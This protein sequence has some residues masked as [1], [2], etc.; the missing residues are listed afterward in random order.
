MKWVL[1]YWL[2]AGTYTG[3]AGA[4]TGQAYFETRPLC[5]KA[6]EAVSGGPIRAVCLMAGETQN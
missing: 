4:F 3:P 1:I 6:H 2:I 5:E